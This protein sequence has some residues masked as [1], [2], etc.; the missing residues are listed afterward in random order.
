MKRVLPCTGDVVIVAGS[1]DVPTTHGTPPEWETNDGITSGVDYPGTGDTEDVSATIDTLTGAGTPRLSA[2]VAADWTG[3][4]LA[5]GFVELQSNS[6]TTLART[7]FLGGPFVGFTSP[8]YAEVDYPMVLLTGSIGVYLAGF[9]GPLKMTV[10]RQT[11]GTPSGDGTYTFDV[12]YVALVVITGQPRGRQY[13]RDDIGRTARHPRSV[14]SGG[15]VG[16]SG[17]YY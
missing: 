14:Q 3:H 12:S 4:D 11:G 2:R 17:H 13:P 1:V 16:W 9:D 8:D 6:N 10:Q 7:D 15:R 5:W